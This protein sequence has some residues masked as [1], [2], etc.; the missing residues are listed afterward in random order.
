MA[1][2]TV[3]NV[4]DLPSPALLVYP[5]RVAQ[6]IRRMIDIVGRRAPAAAAPQDQQ[7]ARSGAAAPR[8]GDHPVQVR[9]H[10]R[11]GDG[12]RRR[13]AG[14]AARLS[15]GRPQRGALRPPRAGVP[16][17]AVRGLVDDAATVSH[18]IAA[19]VAAGVA[20]PLFVDLDGGMHRTG[21]AAGPAPWSCID[22]W[23]R[24]RACARPACTCTTGTCARRISRRG[25]ARPTR[26]SRT[27]RRCCDAMTAPGSRCRPSSPGA[28]RRSR[29]TPRA[30]R[31]MQP[32][33]DGL[34]GCQLRRDAARPPVRAG[35]R[36]AHA[37]S[38]AGRRRT[39]CAWTSATRPSPPRTRIRG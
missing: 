19:A 36:P 37:A 5:D 26:P 4:A 27:S 24:S 11:G 15:A 14:R 38:S 13:G 39:G 12:G 21:I 23:R 16:G 1:W 10:R 35:H 30:R 8:S 28:R 17:D 18:A 32:R 2:Y 34:L 25:G 20:L 9:H 7:D 6:N 31:R 29:F 22:R 33:H 3:D